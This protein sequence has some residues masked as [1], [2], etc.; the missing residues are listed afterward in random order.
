MKLKEKIEQDFKEAFKNKEEVRLSALKMLRAAIS[1]A[2]IEK[3]GKGEGD[4]L[5]DEEIEAVVSKEAKKRREAL[6]IYEREGRND[7]AERER[8]E[9]EI[10]SEYLPEQISEDELRKLAEE[11]IKEAGANSPQEAGKVMAVLMPKIKGRADGS[12]ASRIVRELL[13]N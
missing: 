9:L 12:L 4:E 10:L 7:L 13:G 2:E 11:A 3:R 8:K 5:S 6:E 1:N